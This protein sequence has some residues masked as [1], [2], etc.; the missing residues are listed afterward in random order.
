MRLVALFGLLLMVGCG[1]SV[2]LP[3]AG[4]ASAN[5]T[6]VAAP[7]EDHDAPA[8]CDP[9]IVIVKGPEECDKYTSLSC[10]GAGDDCMY[11]RGEFE[12]IAGCLPP[13]G[14]PGGGGTP[15]CPTW[16]INYPTCSSA[17]PPPTGPCDPTIDPGCEKPLTGADSLA[18]ATGVAQYLRPL[19][20]IPD[21]TARQECENMRN[22]LNTL[23]SNGY[24]FRGAYDTQPG[25]PGAVPHTGAYNPNTGRIH[26]DPKY[27]DAA[28][29]GRPAALRELMDIL[30][31][32]SAHALGKNHPAGYTTTL[33]GPVYSDPY[34]N[35]LSPGEN[36]CLNW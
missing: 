28:A 36:S 33:W 7:D 24:I 18:I 35:R 23:Y 31:H 6:A 12:T 26:I 19:S 5:L 1:D 22:A 20:A 17:P 10:P 9:I 13:G 11:S 2:T 34:Y 15:T 3:K 30:L 29:T 16:D 14:G 32:E 25:D 21:A 8:C 27:L 4:Q